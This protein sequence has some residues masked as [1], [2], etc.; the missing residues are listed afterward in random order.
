MNFNAHYNRSMKRLQTAQTTTDLGAHGV[1]LWLSGHLIQNTTFSHQKT[2]RTGS[3]IRLLT[4]LHDF[5]THIRDPYQPPQPHHSVRPRALTESSVKTPRK[6]LLYIK[7]TCPS[8]R[9]N[10]HSPARRGKLSVRTFLGFFGSLITNP[11]S[12]LLLHIY[13]I[14]KSLLLYI[15]I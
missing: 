10:S 3:T 8:V 15:F 13:I 7:E 6:H 14:C 11:A 2:V 5:R 9:A 4:K 1:R 12:D